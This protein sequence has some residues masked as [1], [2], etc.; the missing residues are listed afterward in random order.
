MHSII[1]KVT[2]FTAI[3]CFALTASAQND[4]LYAKR[5]Q[6]VDSTL[7]IRYTSEAGR[8]IADFISNPS[9]TSA[10]LGRFQ[11]FKPS[12]DSIL[13]LYAIPLEMGFYVLGVSG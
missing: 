4:S 8:Y 7:A 1:V 6:E 13:K 11:H 2:A 12:L 3:I 9:G 10:A 5:L